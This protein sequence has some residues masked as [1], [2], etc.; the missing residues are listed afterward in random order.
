M[1]LDG[2]ARARRA[3]RV[4]EDRLRFGRQVA[5]VRICQRNQRFVIAAIPLRCWPSAAN[6][7]LLRVKTRSRLLAHS[8]IDLAVARW[9]KRCQHRQEHRIMIVVWQTDGRT[10]RQSN[11]CN[12]ATGSRNR[13]ADWPNLIESA[14]GKRPVH[15][16]EAGLSRR[17]RCRRHTASQL[18]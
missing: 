12:D 1:W 2:H 8:S 13:P 7:P 9:R 18:S 14:H 6:W 3:R 5:A 10:D 11:K 4:D 16:L 17:R 15:V